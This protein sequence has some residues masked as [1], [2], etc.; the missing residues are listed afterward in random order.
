MV[1]SNPYPKG[2]FLHNMINQTQEKKS[3]LKPRSFI[4]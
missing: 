2:T 1:D 3:L 4:C